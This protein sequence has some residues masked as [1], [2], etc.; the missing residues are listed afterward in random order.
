M[1]LGKVEPRMVGTKTYSFACLRLLC[2]CVYC[3][4]IVLC[5]CVRVC[6]YIV[7]AIVYACTLCMLLCLLKSY[8]ITIL[9]FRVLC[10]KQIIWFAF[11]GDKFATIEL[12]K[13]C[14]K[15]RPSSGSGF[16]LCKPLAFLIIVCGCRNPSFKAPQLHVRLARKN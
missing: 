5:V 9:Y 11:F 4:V 6:V 1:G 14:V 8:C 13:V 2:V 7:H 16:L 15:S 3:L 10:Q 12:L